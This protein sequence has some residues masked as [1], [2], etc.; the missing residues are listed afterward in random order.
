MVD[1][2]TGVGLVRLLA[3]V[4]VGA[5]AGSVTRLV[6]GALV[7]VRP[8]PGR[9]ETVCA[10]LAVVAV[11]E[12]GVFG[13]AAFAAFGWWCVGASAAD[14]LTR[15]LPNVL[16]V[17]GGSTI[18]VVALV[19]GHGRPAFAGAALLVLPLLSVH[20]LFAHSLGAGD[21]KLAIGLGAVTGV[22]GAEAWM[23][24]ALL[25]P[26]F[27]AGGALILWVTTRRF[28]SAEPGSVVRPPLVLP[29]GPSMCAAAVL[30]LV[31]AG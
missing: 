24:A 1:V 5:T 7:G 3:A 10:L 4:V 23:L 9:C 17:G 25:P 16:T 20:L 12:S 13:I 18:L 21:V 30:S 27:T 15:R 19:T 2:E 22:A 8:R 28:G 29:H 14:L 11:H 31:V 6:V 26:V